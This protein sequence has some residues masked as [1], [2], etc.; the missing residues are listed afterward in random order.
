MPTASGGEGANGSGCLFTP[1]RESKSAL[2]GP[3]GN[4]FLGGFLEV[5]MSARPQYSLDDLAIGLG[6]ELFSRLRQ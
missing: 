3:V 2:V 4:F 5:A 1:I 6:Q